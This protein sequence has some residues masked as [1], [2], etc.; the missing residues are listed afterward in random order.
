MNLQG[1]LVFLEAAWAKAAEV[2]LRPQSVSAGG[3]G[4]GRHPELGAMQKHL[5]SKGFKV[6]STNDEWTT[7]SHPDSS[8]GRYSIHRL[9]SWEHAV[10]GK[11]Q[12]EGK[13]LRDL[14]EYQH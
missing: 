5:E 2:A 7:M 11:R 13:G 12:E 8:Y 3:P 4:S 10:G 1:H 6:K 9:G 14:Q